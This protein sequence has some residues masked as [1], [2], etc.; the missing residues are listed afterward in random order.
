VGAAAVVPACTPANAATEDLGAAGAD[1][2]PLTLAQA[3]AEALRNQPALMQ[4]RGQV[5]AAEGRVEQSRA[6]YL[7]QVSGTGSYERTTANFAP[8]PGITPQGTGGMSGTATQPPITWDPKFNFYQLSATGTQLIYDFGATSGR[9]RSAEAGRD[10]A[11]EN[12]RNAELQALLG[13][14]RA[15]FLARAQHDLVDVADET[16]RNQEKHVEQTRAFVAAGIQPDI[17]LATVLTALANAKLQL[18]TAQNNYAVSQAQLAQAMGVSVRATYALADAELPAVPGEDG[19]AA[20]LTDQAIKYRPDL[21]NLRQQR[22]SQGLLV[23]A[24]RGGYGPSFGGIVNVTDVGSSVY[25]TVPNWYF[26]LTLSWSIFSGGLTRGQVREARGTLESLTG[27]EAATRLQVEV[28]VEQGRLAVQAAKATIA[29]AAEA[30]VNAK[31]Q[32]TLAEGRYTH[33]LGSAVELS[34]AQVAYTS[35]EAQEVQA[36]F[37][38]ASARAQLLGAL[39]AR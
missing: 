29:A 35:A 18:V 9:W 11:V 8:R 37:N 16:V 24:L 12:R 33:G 13:V 19:P 30:V 38:L 27:Q 31:N 22:R 15:Y 1:P 28:D 36:R 39:G 17:N 32:L 25:H 20:P 6:G 21:A 7:P 23:D 2:I 4:A 5:E 34:D 26:G 14:R 3:E 10:A